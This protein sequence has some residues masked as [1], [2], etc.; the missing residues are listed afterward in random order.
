MTVAEIF[1]LSTRVSKISEKSKILD[2]LDSK[3][4][5]LRLKAEPGQVAML[6]K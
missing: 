4:Y 3:G 1:A 2:C 6:S 5:L